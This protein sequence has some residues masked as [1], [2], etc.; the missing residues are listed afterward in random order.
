MNT[1]YI[2]RLEVKNKIFELLLK[3]REYSLLPHDRHMEVLDDI[4]N[5][6]FL[7][8]E[9]DFHKH[10][11][12]ENK[13]KLYSKYYNTNYIYV[14]NILE[15]NTQLITDLSKGVCDGTII[16]K[17][18]LEHI[19]GPK[20]KEIIIKQNER[21]KIKVKE[22]YSDNPC[23]YCGTKT[24]KESVHTRSIDECDVVSRH[25]ATCDRRY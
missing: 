15:G 16:Y 1:I 11:I 14:L 20:T 13:A 19:V 18:Q 2:T 12:R 8:T 21:K 25:C 6:I 3:N 10:Q 9:E 23:R 17:R 7:M 22:T 24:V 4:E 5:L